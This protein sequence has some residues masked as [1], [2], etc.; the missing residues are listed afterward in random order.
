MSQKG[1]RKI[2]N[3]DAAGASD[4]PII[5]TTKIKRN[6]KR[7]KRQKQNLIDPVLLEKHSRGEGTSITGV[8]TKFFKE[9][10]SRKEVYVNFANEQAARTEILRNEEEG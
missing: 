10:L 8:K 7:R 9:K 1:K 5:N 2:L 6:D 4:E 3:E